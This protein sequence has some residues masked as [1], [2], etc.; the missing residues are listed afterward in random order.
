LVIGSSAGGD[1]SGIPRFTF[2]SVTVN[3]GARLIGTGRTGPITFGNPSGVVAPGA[4]P[5][6]LQTGH[7]NFDSAG[8]VLEIEL[9]GTT[10]RSDYDLLTV[11]GI[12]DLIAPL[13]QNAILRY[14]AVEQM[15]A[16]CFEVHAWCET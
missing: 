16:L 13:G 9:N 3:G 12:T 10:P 11:R 4:S 1:N 6:N 15:A 14:F 5:G 7:F 2:S 8:G